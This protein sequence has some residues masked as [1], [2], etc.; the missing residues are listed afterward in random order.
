M[1]VARRVLAVLWI[2]ALPPLPAS[3]I[4]QALCVHHYECATTWYYGPTRHTCG[5]PHAWSGFY[6]GMQFTLGTWQR[7]DA[8]L[9]RHDHPVWSSPRVQ[10]AHAYVI[11]KQDGGSWREWPRSS[12]SCGLR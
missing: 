8:L 1:N 3:F 12:R 7:A 10:V 11:V 6:G 4:R 2:A 5:N 9:H